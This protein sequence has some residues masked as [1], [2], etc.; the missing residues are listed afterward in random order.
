[1]VRVPDGK[2]EEKRTARDGTVR[3][4][5]DALQLV[6]YDGDDTL[7]AHRITSPLFMVG[8]LAS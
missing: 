8:V 6:R 7:S 3:A 5:Q 4:G 2:K 1:M